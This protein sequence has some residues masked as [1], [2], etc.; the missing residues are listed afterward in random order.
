MEALGNVSTT[1]RSLTKNTASKPKLVKKE[2]SI[3]TNQKI[4]FNDSTS[5]SN[6]SSCLNTATA[7]S[8][9]STEKVNILANINNRVIIISNKK[10]SFKWALFLIDKLSRKTRNNSCYVMILLKFKSWF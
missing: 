9:S 1:S 8:S 4:K 6:G 3:E 10:S 5:I 2:E 7:S